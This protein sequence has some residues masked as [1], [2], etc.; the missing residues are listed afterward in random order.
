[1]FCCDWGHPQ[2]DVYSGT[3]GDAARGE[4]AAL[5]N[6]SMSL[7]GAVHGGPASVVEAGLQAGDVRALHR[8]QAEVSSSGSA[9]MRGGA[10][11][12]ILGYGAVATWGWC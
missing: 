1:M 5:P 11:A 4:T 9:V 7:T 2:R 6:T 8:R 12:A 10:F 3:W